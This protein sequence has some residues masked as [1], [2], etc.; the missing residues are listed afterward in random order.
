MK[1][2][3][4]ERE[5]VL[6]ICD[7]SEREALDFIYESYY[8]V[9]ESH[10]R[11][12]YFPQEIDNVFRSLKDKKFIDTYPTMG[13]KFFGFQIL[14]NCR[15]YRDMEIDHDRMHQQRN[16]ISNNKGNIVIAGR[17]VS[18]AYQGINDAAI[19]NDIMQVICN[20]RLELDKLQ[21]D[22]EVKG[23]VCDELDNIERELGSETPSITRISRFMRKLFD[24]IKDVTTMSTLLVH[25]QNLEPLLANALTNLPR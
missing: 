18:N 9:D 4:K 19:F 2:Y 23:D 15:A 25:Y 21:V 5:V 8:V 7:K 14:N 3:G 12:G 6:G 24:R 1:L 13:N 20:M 11:G 22:E 17:D 16:N 10:I